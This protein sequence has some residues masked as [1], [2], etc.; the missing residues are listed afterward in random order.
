MR[1]VS[2]PT[3]TPI[4]EKD[5]P[6]G[7][8]VGNWKPN[9]LYKYYKLG[10]DALVPGLDE[11]KQYRGCPNEVDLNGLCAF[12]GAERF[13][14]LQITAPTITIGIARLGIRSVSS[15]PSS[16]ASCVPGGGLTAKM[17]ADNTSVIAPPNP[18]NCCGGS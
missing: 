11:P 6:I 9:D 13:Q 16:I 3:L 1:D 5:V 17:R 2:R 8:L 7:S 10:R 4:Q 18:D 14:T 15:E 12:N